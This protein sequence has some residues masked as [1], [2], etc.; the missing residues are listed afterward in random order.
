[1]GTFWHMVWSCP[2]LKPFW[3]A[4][5][6]TLSDVTGL[7]VPVDP[8]ILLLSHLEDIEGDRYSKLCLTFA[9]YYARRE[10]LMVWKKAE[11]PTLASWK[12]SVNMV[13]SPVQIDI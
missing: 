8:Q 2:K 7:N 10:I 3:L 13:T 4:V 9:L 11:P 6:T 5:A 12:R 1:M